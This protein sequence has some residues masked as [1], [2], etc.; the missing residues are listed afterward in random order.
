MTINLLK[1]RDQVG[2]YLLMALGFSIPVSTALTNLVLGSLIFFWVLDSISDRFKRW[3]QILKTNPVALAG[4]VFFGVHAIGIVY[5]DVQTEKIIESLSDG[6][7]FLFIGIM[8]IYFKHSDSSFCTAFLLSFL[9]AMGLTLALSYLLWLGFLPNALPM[10]GTAANCMVF[11]LHITQNNFMAFTAFVAAVWARESGTRPVKKG[12]WGILSLL[13]L[14]NVLFMVQGRTGQ[15]IVVVLA[16]YYFFTWDR[17]KSL[18]AGLLILFSFGVFAWLNPSNALFLRTH[19][20]LHEIREWH[21]DKPAQVT[22]AVGIRMEWYVNSLQIIKENPIFGSGTGSFQTAYQK[23]VKNTGKAQ[24][25]NP[26]NEYLMTTVQFGIP[27]LLILMGFFWVQWSYAGFF[28]NS[29][30]VTMARGL[31]LM[32]LV[33]CMTASP[34]QDNA[35]GWFFV[36]MSALLFAKLDTKNGCRDMFKKIRHFVIA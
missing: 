1:K 13:A 2:V 28:E 23:R 14:F 32:T 24:T 33:A 7:K 17:A 29:W 34:L 11:H 5:S 27:G 9:S 15:V 35:E 3:F 12:L 19:Q 10:K 22:E 8:M 4:F 25:D 20:A 21:P 6:A 30:R 31:V 18:V 36:F 26:H 16:L